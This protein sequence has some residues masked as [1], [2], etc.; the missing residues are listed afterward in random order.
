M[1]GVAA[2]TTRQAM[3]EDE[4]EK[5]D[6]ENVFVQPHNLN[7]AYL[8][9]R[10]FQ[11]MRRDQLVGRHSLDCPDMALVALRSGA[12]TYSAIEKEVQA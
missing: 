12:L 11:G 8:A 7:K 9:L 3:V 6:G 1:W 2:R 5:R 10:K 4:Q